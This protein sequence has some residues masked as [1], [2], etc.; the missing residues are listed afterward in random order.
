VSDHCAGWLSTPCTNC[1]T[2]PSTFVISWY[3]RT[4][5]ARGSSCGSG[6]AVMGLRVREGCLLEFGTSGAPR[7]FPRRYGE[8]LMTT[9]LFV[10]YE[11]ID[12]LSEHLASVGGRDWAEA[13]TNAKRGGSTSGEILSNTGVVLRDLA[14]SPDLRRYDVDG[15]GS[16][17]EPVLCTLE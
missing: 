6:K 8:W 10:Y 5:P 15:S 2:T 14:E 11:G 1:T 3:R 4:V 13:L 12:A 16:T 7:S 9:P 17:S